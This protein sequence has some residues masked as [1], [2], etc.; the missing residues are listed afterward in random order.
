MEVSIQR[1]MVIE[2]ET[3]TVNAGS[4][5]GTKYDCG[6]KKELVKKINKIKKK[7]Y[8]IKIFQILLKHDQE[9]TE[10]SNGIFVMFHNLKDD[11]YEE[12]EQFVDE[13]YRIHKKTDKNTRSNILTGSDSIQQSSDYYQANKADDYKYLSSNEKNIM[14]KKQYNQYIYQNNCE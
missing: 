11:V 12:I 9:Y 4:G 2:T 5:L 7:E 14:K 13:I 3:K 10:N 8:L 1:E 6:R